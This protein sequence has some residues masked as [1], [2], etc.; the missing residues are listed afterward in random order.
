[1]NQRVR[2]E[3][4]SYSSFFF[5]LVTYDRHR[6]HVATQA[7]PLRY[8]Y[9]TADSASSQTPFSDVAKKEKEKGNT[10]KSVSLL[11]FSSFVLFGVTRFGFRDSD[12]SSK[13]TSP[14][15]FFI[16]L[17]TEEEEVV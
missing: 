16:R 8:T 5:F 11:F 6:V 3:K 7:S 14:V 2:N 12:T 10:T 15:K 4:S 13:N 9:D 17:T 1:M